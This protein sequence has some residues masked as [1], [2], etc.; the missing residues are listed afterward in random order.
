[1]QR[2]VVMPPVQES[3]LLSRVKQTG[4]L[5]RSTCTWGALHQRDSKRTG[6]RRK[7]TCSHRLTQQP[8]SR[9]NA[10]GESFNAFKKKLTP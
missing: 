4:G 3:L 9:L 5:Q 8:L 10:C 7:Q 6:P 2:Q 1:M